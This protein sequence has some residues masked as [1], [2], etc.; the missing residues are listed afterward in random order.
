MWVLC[1]KIAEELSK[2]GITTKEDVYRLVQSGKIKAILVGKV[3]RVPE[4][5]IQR[6]KKGK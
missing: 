3:W 6:L 1:Q 2:N 4:E 5:E